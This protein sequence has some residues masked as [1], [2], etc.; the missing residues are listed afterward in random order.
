MYV[1]G[2]KEENDKRFRK[3]NAA[4]QRKHAQKRKAE[5]PEQF[6]NCQSKM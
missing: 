1:Q 5:N 4:N 3:E 2:I 6:L